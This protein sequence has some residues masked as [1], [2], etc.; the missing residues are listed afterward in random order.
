[1]LW[2]FAEFYDRWYCFRIDCT[3]LITNT[4]IYFPTVIIPLNIKNSFTFEYAGFV[5]FSCRLNV[6]PYFDIQAAKSR[7]DDTGTVS[8]TNISGKYPRYNDNSPSFSFEVVKELKLKLLRVQVLQEY[9]RFGPPPPLS[10]KQ[11]K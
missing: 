11:I 7:C 8:D 9:R 4:E 1:M 3:T 10:Q 5:S 6:E 2:R